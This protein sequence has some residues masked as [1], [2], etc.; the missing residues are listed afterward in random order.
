MLNFIIYFVVIVLFGVCVV[1][2]YIN[3]IDFLFLFLIVFGWYLFVYYCDFFCLGRKGVW[4]LS[5]YYFL[6]FFVF[7]DCVVYLGLVELGLCFK[8]LTVKFCILLLIFFLW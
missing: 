5:Y 6:I 2:L 1:I 7:F 3:F 8:F 4:V